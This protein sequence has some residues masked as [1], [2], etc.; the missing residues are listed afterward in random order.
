MKSETKW[1]GIDIVATCV[2]N[3]FTL[4]FKAD[5]R[6]YR[7]RTAD[8]CG[9]FDMRTDRFLPTSEAIFSEDMEAYYRYAGNNL[10]A[11]ETIAAQCAQ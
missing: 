8:R 1:E 9:I 3:K 6:F 7:I 10:K 5:K 11:M 4:N 2:K